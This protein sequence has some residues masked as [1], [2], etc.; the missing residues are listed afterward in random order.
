MKS[1]LRAEPVYSALV[2]IKGF[3]FALSR[4]KEAQEQCDVSLKRE[5]VPLFH[6]LYISF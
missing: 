1:L 4:C 3:S 5:E 2:R 6:L